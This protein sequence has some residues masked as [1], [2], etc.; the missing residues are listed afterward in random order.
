MVDHPTWMRVSDSLQAYA[1]AID[2]ADIPGILALFTADA[3]W[4]YAP[5]GSHRGHEAI[6]GF[7]RER[8]V[9]FA[10][11]SHHVGPPVVRRDRDGSLE[12]T[13]YYIA[14][15]LLKD[16]TRYTVHGR[17]VDTFREEGST[18]LISWRRVVVHVTEGTKRVYNMLPRHESP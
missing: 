4:D 13:A 9:P 5:E 3:V 8:L 17:Y 14:T 11:T 16:A 2:R 1:D 10:R 15:H 6:R 18:L 12:S 7:F